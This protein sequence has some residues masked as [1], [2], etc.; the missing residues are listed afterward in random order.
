MVGGEAIAVARHAAGADGDLPRMKEA[1]FP[2][3]KVRRE[4]VA[5]EKAMKE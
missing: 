2:V 1:A 5:A 4:A 3:L